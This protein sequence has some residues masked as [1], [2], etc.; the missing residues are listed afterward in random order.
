[1][2]RLQKIRIHWGAWLAAAWLL[3]GCQTVPTLGLPIHR[4]DI[5]QGNVVTQEMV[6]KLRPGMTRQQ[7]R[8]VLGTPPLVDPFHV[9]RWDYVYYYNKA[10]KVI[11]HRRLILL[12]E[13]DTL[14][15]IEGDVIPGAVGTAPKPAAPAPTTPASGSKPQAAAAPG[16]TG[17]ASKPTPAPGP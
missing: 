10:G 1:M 7:V 4:I 14:K 15:R 8:F 16:E 17:Q 6:E 5:Q 2:I 12:F 11:E 13:A 9:D 3:A